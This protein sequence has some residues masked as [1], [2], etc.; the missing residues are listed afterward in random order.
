MFISK[1]QTHSGVICR[2]FKQKTGL[3]PMEYLNFLRMEAAKALF[4]AS[5]RNTDEIAYRAGYRSTK[6]FNRAFR[7]YTGM[8]TREYRKNGNDN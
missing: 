7:A 3:S 6:F 2:A 8:S 4:A 5:N 1:K